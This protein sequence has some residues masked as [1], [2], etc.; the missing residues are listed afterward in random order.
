MAAKKATSKKKKTA[1]KK[2]I[3]KTTKKTTK[4]TVKRT[5]KTAKPTKK[6]ATKK[7]SKKTTAKRKKATKKSVYQAQDYR[8]PVQEESPTGEQELTLLMKK[9]ERPKR[10]KIRISV[11]RAIL[12]I[13]LLISVGIGISFLALRARFSRSAAVTQGKL[14]VEGLQK[15]VLV[16]RDKLGVP[17]IEAKNNH[18]LFFAVGYTMASERLWQMTAMKM[19]S[20]GRLSEIIGEK[21]LPLDLFT[22]TLGIRRYYVRAYQKLPQHIKATLQ[23]FADGVN[24][25]VSNQVLPP[26]FFLVNYRPEKWK[27]EDSLTI[28]GLMNAMLSTNLNEEFIFLKLAQALGH[29][30]AAWLFPTYPG[31]DLPFQEAKKLEGVSLAGLFQDEQSGFAGIFSVL[32]NLPWGIPA[33]NNWAFGPNRTKSGKSIIANDTHLEIGMPGNWI[34][35]N[36]SSPDYRAAGVM[37]PGT[38]IIALGANPYFSWGATMVMGDTQDL[39]LEKLKVQNGK[40]YYLYRGKWFPVLEKKAEFFVKGKGKVEKVLR[41]TKHGPL[42]N[43]VVSNQPLSG[44]QPV[45]LKIKYGVAGRWTAADGDLSMIGFYELAKAKNLQEARKA[46]SKIRTICL[47]IVYGNANHI[48]WQVTGYYPKRKKG[49]G[50]FPSPGWTGEYEWMGYSSFE[51]NPHVKDPAAGVIGTA[52]HRTVAENYPIRLSSSWYSPGRS[53]RL[54]QYFKHVKKADFHTVLKMQSDV[55]SVIGQK[56]RDVI[57]AIV[58]EKQVGKDIFSL[59]KKFNG[60]MD[61]NSAPAAFM[62]AFYHF[63]ARETFADELG[64]IHSSLWDAFLSANRRSYGAVEDHLLYRS[65]SPFYDNVNTKAKESKKDIIIK[66]LK[67]AYAFLQDE[68][69]EDESS[70]QWGK[71]H[72]YHFNHAFGKKNAI[73]HSYFSRGPYPASGGMHTLN[74]SGVNW[75]KDFDT[76]IIPALRLIADYSQEEPNY[77]IIYAGI[78]GNPESNHYDDMLPLWMSV[79]NHPLPLKKKNIEKQYTEKL[80]LLP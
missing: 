17:Y 14:K 10:D 52:N 24:A 76:F 72:T 5:T 34:M 37:L 6:K 16:L 8:A 39:F 74:V 4:K 77:L 66:S 33:S 1:K 51:Q 40:M 60:S 58:T 45:Q 59:V 75:G 70:W 19:L 20:Q 13:L 36:L 67:R 57:L 50:L 65:T 46:M 22:R 64:G 23:A 53:Y 68:M 47:N 61:K 9:D 7:T 48:A 30:K 28:F 21:T 71:L 18:D 42:Y 62:S 38:P 55:I 78:S 80:E 35:M 11:R 44:F 27:P 12:I 32:D 79:Q 54:Q 31:E 26:E 69:G 29:Q 15:P 56:A 49:R 3:K 2:T 25:Y 73:L 43:E 41:F 63:F